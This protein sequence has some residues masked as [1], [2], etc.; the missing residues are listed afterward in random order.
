MVHDWC[1]RGTPNNYRI[2][3][4]KACTMVSELGLAEYRSLAKKNSNDC[5][6][7]CC[8]P[9]ILAL[10][11]THNEDER[12]TRQ[13]DPG[14]SVIRDSKGKFCLKAKLLKFY[15]FYVDGSSDASRD[16]YGFRLALPF[17]W[18]GLSA[19]TGLMRSIS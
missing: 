15:L 19:T 4:S 10:T 16:L 6:R 3:P 12:Q 14:H 1:D 9:K 2:I 13:A 17:T 11:S 5:I 8:Q 18:R 7:T